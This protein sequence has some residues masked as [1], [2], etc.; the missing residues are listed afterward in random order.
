VFEFEKVEEHTG[1][2]RLTSLMSLVFVAFS[3]RRTGT[4]TGTGTGMQV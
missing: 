3:F 2:S 1:D 4:G